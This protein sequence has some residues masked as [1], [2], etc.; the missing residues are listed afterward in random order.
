VSAL[1]VAARVKKTDIGSD[2]HRQ[3]S[4]LATREDVASSPWRNRVFLKDSGET[5]SGRD[6]ATE[7]HVFER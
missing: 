5:H 3:F 4:E 2:L 6:G 7:E 1:E